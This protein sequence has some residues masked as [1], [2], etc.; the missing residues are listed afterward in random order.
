MG[1]R[2]FYIQIVIG[3]AWNVFWGM[4]SIDKAS[5]YDFHIDFS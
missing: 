1:R 5:F 4:L 2:P 3:W